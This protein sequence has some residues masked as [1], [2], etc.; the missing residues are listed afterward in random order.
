VAR[1]WRRPLLRRSGHA[2]SDPT[3]RAGGRR[4]RRTAAGARA[5][6]GHRLPGQRRPGLPAH[7]RRVPDS[8]RADPTRSTL[9]SCAT[10]WR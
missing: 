10:S 9:P 4:H 2:R 8:S 6:D 1:P 3:L 5:R 7:D